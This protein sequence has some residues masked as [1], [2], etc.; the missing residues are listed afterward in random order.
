M[1][2]PIAIHNLGCLLERVHFYR[3]RIYGKHPDVKFVP[4]PFYMGD[5][6]LGLVCNTMCISW[7]LFV[8]V[9]FSL[10]TYF[11][12]TKDNMNYASVITIAVISSSL[13]VSKFSA[14]HVHLPPFLVE[15][16]GLVFL[17]VRYSVSNSENRTRQLTTPTAQGYITKA[18][19]HTPTDI[20]NRRRNPKKTSL[21]EKLRMFL[22][23][24]CSLVHQP[25]RSWLI[26]LTSQNSSQMF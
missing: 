24:G 10:P 4:G 2:F 3:R 17:W 22:G 21:T 16:K 13:C 23:S 8:S 25:S 7:T 6:W 9:L 12:V 15:K 1:S 11:P 19:S 26:V 5:G 20:K 18:P 14:S